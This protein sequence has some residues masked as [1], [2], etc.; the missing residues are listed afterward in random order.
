MQNEKNACFTQERGLSRV[1]LREN[2]L[3][4]S[5]QDMGYHCLRTYYRLCNPPTWQLAQHEQLSYTAALA[6]VNSC[7]D[8][9][10]TI[11]RDVFSR[12]GRYY[13]TAQAVKAAAQ[14]HGIPCSI[15]WQVVRKA[16]AIIVDELIG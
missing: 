13:S 8:F 2:A 14:E 16:A 7:N 4:R 15:A 6:A 9:E 5:G 12:K 11:L 1:N 3:I 10:R